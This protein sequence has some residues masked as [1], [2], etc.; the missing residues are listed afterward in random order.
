MYIRTHLFFIFKITTTVRIS[1]PH[2]N[3]FSPSFRIKSTFL[4]YYVFIDKIVLQ[5]GKKKKKKQK[6]KY[7]SSARVGYNMQ[8]F[9]LD[10]RHLRKLYDYNIILYTQDMYSFVSQVYNII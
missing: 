10:F 6:K 4:M 2:P 3:I 9:D 7:L 1:S 8:V 5:A